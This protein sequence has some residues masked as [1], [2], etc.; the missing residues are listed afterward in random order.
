M[1]V[2]CQYTKLFNSY[3]V[4]AYFFG[5]PCILDEYIDRNILFG[6]LSNDFQNTIRHITV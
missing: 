1:K 6:R 5:P 2:S 4:T 3:K